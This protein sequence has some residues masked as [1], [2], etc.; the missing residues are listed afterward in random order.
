VW[1]AWPACPRAIEVTKSF[2]SCSADLHLSNRT[3][4]H[5]ENVLNL[6]TSRV[7]RGWHW[8]W[9]TFQYSGMRRNVDCGLHFQ[10]CPR[11][12]CQK[13][14]PNACYLFTNLQSSWSQNT[15]IFM[16]PRNIW[17]RHTRLSFPLQQWVSER[18]SVLRYTC[19]HFF[20]RTT[21]RH[22]VGFCFED[23]V[24]RNGSPGSAL[25]AVVGWGLQKH[26]VQRSVWRDTAWGPT[27]MGPQ[28]RCTDC[29]MYCDVEWSLVRC[30]FET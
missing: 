10:G 21:E 16:P 20:I 17:G 7:L 3:F 25:S 12:W 8:H 2:F 4:V 23:F 14:P 30:E 11:T 6:P 13:A 29:H 22:A 19:T 9:W 18:Y 28:Q 5:S 1:P 24:I 26:P 15:R 27:S